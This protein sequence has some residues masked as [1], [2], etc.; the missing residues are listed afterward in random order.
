MP[1]L[2]RAGNFDIGLIKTHLSSGFSLIRIQPNPSPQ[3]GIRWWPELRDQPQDLGEQHSRRGDL[4]HLEGNVAA[5]ADELGDDLDRFSKRVSDQ[6]LIG[7]GV[8]SLRRSCRYC[9]RAHEAEAA[10]RWR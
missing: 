6:S 10:R 7:S 5:V 9:R 3:R 2:F 4:G 1:A 8:A